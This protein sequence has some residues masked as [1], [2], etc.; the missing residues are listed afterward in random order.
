MNLFS[1]THLVEL[2]KTLPDPEKAVRGEEGYSPVIRLPLHEWNADLD[3]EHPDREFED[4]KHS[5]VEFEIVM[6]KDTRGA[7][8]PRW[9]LRGLAAM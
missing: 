9:V 2:A 3:A 7:R 8:F 1:L 5:Y 4:H 6:W